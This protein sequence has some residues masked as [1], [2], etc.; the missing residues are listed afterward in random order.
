VIV[1]SGFGALMTVLLLKAI[2]IQFD[3]AISERLAEMSY[4][5]AKGKNVVNV[6]LVDFRA[7]DT[8]G[9]IVVVATAALGIAALV[10]TGLKKR[11]EAAES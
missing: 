6:I 10:A 8:F 2:H 3:G 4:P 1:A 11:K 5:E 9:E 7:L